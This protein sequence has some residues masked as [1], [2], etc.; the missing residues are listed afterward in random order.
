MK[1]HDKDTIRIALETLLKITKYELCGYC[2]KRCILKLTKQPYWTARIY[3]N[4]WQE[5]I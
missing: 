2:Y 1:E 3:M 4:L 5:F